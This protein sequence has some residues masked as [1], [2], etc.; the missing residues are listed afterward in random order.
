MTPTS[1]PDIA[2][3]AI[4][5]L[6]SHGFT[7]EGYALGRLGHVLCVLPVA[8]PAFSARLVAATAALENA[9]LDCAAQPATGVVVAAPRVVVA[10]G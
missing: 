7:P 6:A 3:L 5:A 1:C 4:A 8:G 9:G 2:T 10:A